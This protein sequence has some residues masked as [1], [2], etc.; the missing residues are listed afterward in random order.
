MPSKAPAQW[1]DVESLVPWDQNPRVNAAAV[2]DVAKSISRFGFGSV[3]IARTSTRE[4]I[5]GHTRVLAAKQLGLDKVPVRFLDLDESEA[6][7]L[8]VADNKLS[9]LAD[10]DADVLGDV[11]RDL[12]SDGVD[13]DGLGFGD[14]ELRELLAALDPGL[15][16]PEEDA[17]EVQDE[18]QSEAGRVY[19][20]GPHRLMCG[21]CRDPAVVAALLDGSEIQMAFTSPPY[22]SQRTY[23]ESSGFKPIRP[24]DYVDW[25]DAVQA[26]V[27]A[28]LAADG[29][30]FVNIKEHCEDGQRSLYVKDLTIAHVR[31][32]GWY[33]VDEL[34][35]HRNSIPG[36]FP[37]RFKNLW[38]PV[39]HF[40]AESGTG[41]KCDHYAVASPGDG[42]T[43]SPGL[44][45]RMKATG[46]EENGA[47]LTPQSMVLPGNVLHIN[48]DS[49]QVQSGHTAPF[50]LALPRF[51]IKAYTDTGDVVF[52]PF[53]GSG[54]T[55]LAAA[56]EG[57]IGYGCELSAGY[58]DVIRRRWT[59]YATENG[60]DPGPGAL[61]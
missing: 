23:D 47:E 13:L 3:I 20:L 43:Y 36:L 52:D 9:E 60:I 29:S 61:D 45:K 58:C 38:E 35:W 19:E 24:D 18:V 11:L 14:E 53:L 32:W 12:E 54:T 27:R 8:A 1:V 42:F 55:L 16:E 40:G 22:A 4:I 33:F 37:G 39:L 26:N 44:V 5:A 10:W 7:A 49:Q 31:R 46:S 28:H 57:R 34:C 59:K 25:F 41:I 56:A 6:H 21:D 30:W 2:A 17:P 51:F 48:A 50:P 15:V